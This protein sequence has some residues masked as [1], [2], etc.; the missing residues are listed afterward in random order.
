MKIRNLY[1]F[2]AGPLRG[3][4]QCLCFKD[5]DTEALSGQDHAGKKTRN[6]K[7]LG[8]RTLIPGAGSVT[9]RTTGPLLVTSPSFHHPSAFFTSS[10]WNPSGP[11]VS[12]RHFLLLLFFLKAAGQGSARGSKGLSQAL[13]LV[14]QRKVF[15]PAP[16]EE[17]D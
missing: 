5:E 10:S 12:L 4:S 1:L 2:S 6:S 11:G 3:R 17:K 8:R 16:E 9:D 14:M 7:C 15:A 13:G